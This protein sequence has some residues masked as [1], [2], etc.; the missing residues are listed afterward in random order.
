MCSG[1]NNLTI[2]HDQD[3]IR[4]HYRSYSL[5]NDQCRH[6]SELFLQRDLDLA[7][8]IGIDSA[9]AVIQNDNF[10]F[11]QQG[12]GNAKSLTLTSGNV[13]SSLLDLSIITIRER[14]DVFISLR[15]SACFHHFFAGSVHVAPFD[16][17]LDSTG[18]QNV[19]LKYHR[20]V[21]PEIFEFIVANVMSTD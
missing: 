3:L 5:C 16:V 13:N 20:N 14:T 2:L 9:C 7:V 10:R 6:P 11:F 12:S 19:F 18:K 15:L 8:G 4:V 21:S 17:F 1:F